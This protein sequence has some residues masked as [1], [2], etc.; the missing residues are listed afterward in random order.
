MR[1][2]VSDIN[3]FDQRVGHLVP[4]WTASTPP[5]ARPMAGHWCR[6]EPLNPARHA[7]GLYQANRADEKGR[8]RTYLPY[9][10]F[11][12]VTSYRAWLEGVAGCE[13]P[14]FFAIIDGQGRAVAAPRVRLRGHLQSGG[15]RKGPQPG[16]GVVLDHRRRVAAPAAYARWLAPKNFDAESRQRIALSKLTRPDAL[17]AP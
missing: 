10:H 7:D 11:D 13:D 9:G 4:G 6:L 5:T 17:S 8:M 1:V 12:S 2:R 16:H 3:D 14:M 15:R